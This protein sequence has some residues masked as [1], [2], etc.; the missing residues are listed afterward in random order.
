MWC[1]AYSCGAMLA[2]GDACLWDVSVFEWS[3]QA[4]DIA[5]RAVPLV[6]YFRTHG[7]PTTPIVMAE[8][9]D[10]PVN[11]PCQV[12]INQT[13]VLLFVPLAVAWSDSS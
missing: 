4:S 6:Q 13:R 10:W 5:A 1:D 9:S 3:V 8:G 2:C 7:H 11:I 12:V